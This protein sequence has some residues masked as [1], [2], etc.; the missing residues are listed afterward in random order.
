MCGSGHRVATKATQRRVVRGQKISHKVIGCRNG[1][2]VIGRIVHTCA[3]RT[4]TTTTRVT[5]PTSKGC[6]SPVIL[7]GSILDPESCLLCSGAERLFG[8]RFFG[9][10]TAQPQ[11]CSRYA[12]IRVRE[13]C[14][15][16]SPT[17][18]IYARTCLR[19][20]TNRQPPPPDA[21][22]HG[23]ARS[24]AMRRSSSLGVRYIP[25][26]AMLL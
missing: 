8:S 7:S 2:V 18:N 20:R 3:G 13:P 11:S 19:F 21:R 22:G 14:T 17:T 1:V 15:G 16:Q 23:V 12:A 10:A 25:V 9:I 4:A 24:I 5:A 6:G 26:V